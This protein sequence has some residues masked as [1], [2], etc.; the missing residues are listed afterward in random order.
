MN[1]PEIVHPTGL[2]N[3]SILTD[4]SGFRF[5]FS[6]ETVVGFRAPGQNWV[7]RENNWG[8]TTGKHLKWIDGGSKEAQK[9]RMSED[10]FEAYIHGTYVTRSLVSA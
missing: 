9:L 4:A 3:F 6:Y 5:A 1:L 10:A 7:V 2:H 8:P